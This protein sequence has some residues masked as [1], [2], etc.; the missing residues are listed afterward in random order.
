M[1]SELNNM[2]KEFQSIGEKYNI[3]YSL[4]QRECL[5]VSSDAY[6]VEIMMSKPLSLVNHTTLM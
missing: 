3:N 5:R 6:L 1:L 4:L 2:C